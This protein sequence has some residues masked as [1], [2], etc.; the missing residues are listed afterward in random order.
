MTDN[1]MRMFEKV[2]TAWRDENTATD[3]L[4]PG[5]CSTARERASAYRM[6]LDLLH[7]VSGGKFGQSL[8]DQPSPYRSGVEA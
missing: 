4:A 7:D 2:L 6:T 8:A 3:R 1:D 5:G